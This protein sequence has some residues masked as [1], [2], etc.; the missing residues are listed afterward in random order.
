MGLNAHFHSTIPSQVR[1]VYLRKLKP[2]ALYCVD[3]S[4]RRGYILYNDNLWLGIYYD[5][6]IL[7][8]YSTSTWHRIVCRGKRW[9]W[10]ILKSRE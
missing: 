3:D 5:D 8:Q 1:S 2:K 4:I 9:L 6:S 7:I 10:P